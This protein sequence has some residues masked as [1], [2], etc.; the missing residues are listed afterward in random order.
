MKA[1]LA[2]ATLLPL[3]VSLIPSVTGVGPTCGTHCGTERWPVKTLSDPGAASVNMSPTP[4]AVSNLVAAAA[5]TES[6]NNTRLN[7]LEKETF[8]VHALLMGYKLETDHDFHLVIEDPQTH[9]T[10]IAEIPDPQCSGVC[11]SIAEA[12]ITQARTTFATAF[13]AAPPDASYTALTPP[14][15]VTITGVGFFDFYHGQTGVAKN[16]VEIHPVLSIVLPALHVAKHDPAV[17]P[18]PG[19]TES[20]HCLPE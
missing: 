17:E 7:D 9:D 16:C 18:T 12:Q 13:A 14:A 11:A 3:A 19:P 1:G 8:I 5:P 2:A 6:S 15:A 20:Y 4:A 10:M